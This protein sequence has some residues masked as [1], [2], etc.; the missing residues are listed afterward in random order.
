MVSA[1]LA[2]SAPLHR[3][4]GVRVIAFALFAISAYLILNGAL[5]SL[6]LMA[7]ASGRYFLGEYTTMG[8]LL[9]FVVGAVLIGIG[10]GL[11]NGWRSARRLAVVAAALTLATSV[12]PISAAFSYWQTSGI[13]IYGV[14]IILAVIAIQYLLRPEVRDYFSARTVQRST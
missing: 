1:L 3:P 6:G 12:V 2:E 14:K 5:I 4:G 7:L 8:P 9:F 13:V 10:I 11:L